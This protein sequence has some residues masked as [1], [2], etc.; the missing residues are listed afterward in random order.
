MTNSIHILQ[1]SSIS[2]DLLGGNAP[3]DLIKGHLRTVNDGNDDPLYINASRGLS[4]LPNPPGWSIPFDNY[5]PVKQYHWVAKIQSFQAG[6]FETTVTR[7]DLH[8]LA[9][10]MDRPRATGK[11]EEG[12]RRENDVISSI[13]RSKKKVRHLIKSIGCDRMLTLTKKENDPDNYAS[14]EQWAADWKRFI[15]LCKDAGCGLQYVSVLE[16]HKKGNLHLHAAIVGHAN[17]KLMRRIWWSICGG[18]GLGNIDIAMRRNCTEHKRRAGLA[19]YVSKYLVKQLG[20]VQFNK[21][22]YWSSRHKLPPV[23]RYIL[24]DESLID[25]LFNICGLL[26]LELTEVF[27]SMFQFPNGNGLWFSFDDNMASPVPF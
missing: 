6:G 16:V 24:N 2:G 1:D 13:Q 20:H 4:F 8:E 11:R 5:D 18:R 3:L 17:I 9:E 23:K 22:R 15:R 27:S 12:E 19:K 26:S 10:L 21:K 25:A 7:Q 14:V